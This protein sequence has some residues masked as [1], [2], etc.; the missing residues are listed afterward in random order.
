MIHR[1]ERLYS[2]KKLGV[3][4]D[5]RPVSVITPTDLGVKCQHR[6]CDNLGRKALPK[7]AFL[8]FAD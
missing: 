5:V 1:L 6:A 4:I 3:K 8:S 2:R 7:R